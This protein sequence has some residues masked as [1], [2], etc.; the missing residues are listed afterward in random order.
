MP[1]PL[2]D[3]ERDRILFLWE[4]GDT[5]RGIALSVLGS[6]R[7]KSRVHRVIVSERRRARIS[8]DPNALE[9]LVAEMRSR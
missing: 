6:R 1:P 9:A 8:H 4:K 7:Y 2:K 5:V 3:L